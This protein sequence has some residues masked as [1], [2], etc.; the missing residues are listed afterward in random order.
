MSTLTPTYDAFVEQLRRFR[1][2]D[3]QVALQIGL[4][5]FAAT[6]IPAFL[7][8]AATESLFSLESLLRIGLL[9]LMSGALIFAFSLWVFPSVINILFRP[10]RPS[11][12]ETAIKV[13]SLYRG[14]NDRLANALQVFRKHES[15][16]EN[17]STVLID[18]A[19]AQIAGPLS[20]EDFCRKVDYSGMRKSLR[21]AS[22]V[23]APAIAIWLFFAASFNAAAYRLLHPRQDFTMQPNVT[24]LV[25]PGDKTVL[26]GE[27]VPVRIWTSDVNASSVNLSLAA[28]DKVE[29]V[30]LQKS[31]DDTFRYT[32]E[33]VRDSLR[34]FAAVGKAKSQ[35]YRISVR[36]LPMLRN[37]QVKITPPSYARLEPYMLEENVGDVN[38]LK[39]S[40]L[41]ISGEC[42]KP[43][44]DGTIVFDSGDSL[45]V[46]VT[47][48]R[49]SASFSLQKDDSYYFALRDRHGYAS[50]NPIEYHLKVIPDQYPF[51]NVPVPGR[52]V[53]LGE[54]MLI[55][56][57]IEAQDDYG[58]SRIRLAYQ[59]IPGG[60]GDIDST[61]F[62]SQD[63]EGL[64][65]GA[66]QL[67]FAFNWELSKSN[68]LPNDLLVYF[69]E[70]Y[71]NDTVSGPKKARSKIYRARFP[72]IYELYQEIA[73]SQ[74]D[75]TEQL[76]NVYEKSQQL[77]KEIED[78]SLEMKRSTDLDWQKQQQVEAALKQ[79][80][81][82][83][84]QLQ[85]LSDKMEQ[86]LESMEENNLVSS[87]TM[88]KYQELQQLFREIM[89][90]E[91]KRAM[92]KVAEA[93]QNL[94][95]QLIQKAMEDLKLSEEDFK[96]SIERTISLLKRLKTEQKLDQAMRM[97]QD[98]AERERKLTEEAN[99]KNRE[100][101]KLLDEQ[102]KINENTE[103][104]SDLLK[105][106]QQE[107]SEQPGLPQEQIDQAL[108]QMDSSQLTQQ[109]EQMK[110]SLQSGQQS[111]MQQQSSRIQQTFDKVAQNLQKAKE[112]MSGEAQR[113]AMQ[114][115]RQGAHDLLELSKRQENLMNQTKD[116][117][118]NSAQL[119]QAAEQQQD[120]ASALSRTIDRI[121]DASKES[122][123]IDPR[124]AQSLGQAAA[125]MEKA[126]QEMEN[127]NNPSAAG[128]Q[129][130]AMAT[131]NNAVKNLQASM[132]SMMQGSGTG[133]SMQQF[134]EQMQGMAGAQQGINQETLGLGMGQQ[135]S[136]AQ[137]AAM[138]RLAAEQGAVRKSMEELAKEAG[139]LSEILGSMDKIVEDMKEVEKD[140][141]QQNV[142]RET[143]ER[144]NRILSRMLDSQR[145]MRE[146]EYSQKRKAETG[147][148]YLSISPDG[149]PADLGERRS[150]L[151]QDL[152]RA[153]SE[154]YTRDYL[155]LIRK[156]FEA[157]MQNE[158]EK[159][160]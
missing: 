97:T 67:N 75:A 20:G 91:L 102:E 12:I 146:R 107:M 99:Q 96:K 73:E 79:H 6:C 158:A 36:E 24:L 11:L 45:A 126:L 143:I 141:A 117:P 1:R 95:Q 22:G 3:K 50:N 32:I 53:D 88:K 101:D 160:Q 151:Q 23:L 60:E 31:R 74:T 144:Q 71:D 152:L 83:Q 112:A 51:V 54:D 72:S 44:A 46:E 52:D 145:S 17:Y 14:V 10:E 57:T 81:E 134:I 124:I 105:E 159:T 82:M 153:K 108:A 135:L 90:P 69:V 39:G 103:G 92:E 70:A 129:G 110:S 130:Q 147:K 85:Q 29:T 157:L 18:A 123:Y 100:M 49:I 34:Y 118:A 27:D 37:L 19:L 13:G 150:R 78:L 89:T 5:K 28:L 125:S 122:F 26:K 40:R 149:L 84:Q 106:L 62:V 2:R 87:E 113:K 30:E 93:M 138:A 25:H 131:L 140:F 77:K 61:R 48:Q 120:I 104:L 119:S 65:Y 136:L 121:F 41:Q 137:Q 148:E 35:T 109:L 9:L 114:A 66:E 128:Q 63:L 94:D 58:I 15:N 98:L 139:N 80:R 7:L 21:I 59:I 132:Q 4:L 42:N 116:M 68:M 142:N 133:M 33:S 76:E 111:D 16:R 156:Y 154:G 47:G 43:I 86:M 8:A 55:P 155:E 56:M 115:M 38:A 64:N 127:R